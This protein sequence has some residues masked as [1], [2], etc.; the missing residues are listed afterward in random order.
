MEAEYFLLPFLRDLMLGVRGDIVKQ[1]MVLKDSF[2]FWNIRDFFFQFLCV[3]V[4]FNLVTDA[5]LLRWKCNL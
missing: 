1:V 4:S 3:C 2:G 5:L